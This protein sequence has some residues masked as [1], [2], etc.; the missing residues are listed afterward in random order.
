M[1][2]RRVAGAA[3]GISLLV[4]VSGC[5]PAEIAEA[6]REIHASVGQLE[7]AL[8]DEARF[9]NPKLMKAY[10]DD[11]DDGTYL[12]VTA[13]EP[14][15]PESYESDAMIYGATVDGQEI[16]VRAA[17]R[18]HGETGGGWSYKSANQVLC[19]TFTVLTG[20]DVRVD[21][22]DDHCPDFILSGAQEQSLSDV[23]L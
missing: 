5:T 17:F 16:T 1:L 11:P 14:A 23:S 10:I 18:G 8:R 22:A 2:A 19:V 21:I 20:T 4:A 7:K 13:A 9:G 6:H 12:G 15:V 3:I